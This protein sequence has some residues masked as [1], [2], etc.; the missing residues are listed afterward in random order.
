M[1]DSNRSSDNY[2]FRID[3]YLP[4]ANE[5]CKGYVFTGVC[6]ST[7]GGG[8]L[9][10]RGISVQGVSLSRGVSVLRVVSVQTAFCPGGVSVK[11][12][13]LVR[14]RAHGTH[15]TGMHFCD[16][17]GFC[18]LRSRVSK[19]KGNT[20]VCISL[21]YIL[22][23]HN[24]FVAKRGRKCYYNFIIKCVNLVVTS[25]YPVGSENVTTKSCHKSDQ[26][27]QDLNVCYEKQNKNT[28]N[29]WFSLWKPFVV[30]FSSSS[31]WGIWKS[32]V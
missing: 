1:L 29:V 19:V 10:P 28:W 20:S 18:H 30:A 26:E 25:S 8:G 15:P 22:T 13:P 23:C 7:G 16:E 31:A 2:C 5:V 24:I 14:L 32:S 17:V 4:P 3:Q 11:E 12:T 6:V 27:K 9:C 21:C